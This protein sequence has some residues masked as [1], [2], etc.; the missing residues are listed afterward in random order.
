MAEFQKK[1]WIS[2]ARGGAI[3]GVVAVHTANLFDLPPLLY[4][5]AACGMYCVVAFFIISGYLTFISLSR[6]PVIN[7]SGYK[8][9]IIHKI[10]RLIPVLY[11]TVFLRELI[12]LFFVDDVR[13]RDAFFALK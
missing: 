13:F 2:K 12:R 5:G 1:N 7:L 11:V 10:S 9:Y 3:I 6:R 4:R 8:V